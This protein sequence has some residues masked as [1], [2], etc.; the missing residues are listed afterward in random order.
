MS[1]Y[2]QV[3]T[4]GAVCSSCEH[5]GLIIITSIGPLIKCK[6]YG[7]FYENNQAEHC[8]NHYVPKI[9]EDKK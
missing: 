6:L 1:D 3:I 8:I 5:H 2:P 4:P 9:E 7:A